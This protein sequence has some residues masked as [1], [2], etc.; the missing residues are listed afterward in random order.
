MITT[1]KIKYSCDNQSGL[2]QY[3]RQYNSC[4][5]VAVNLLLNETVVKSSSYYKKQNSII[6]QK[7]SQMNNIELMNYWM[8]LSCIDDAVALIKSR[9]ALMK[10][11]KQK[12]QSYKD[13]LKNLQNKL[14]TAKK[15]KTINNKINK[16]N[17][18]IQKLQS[19]S[20]KIIFGGRNLFE[21]RCKYNISHDEFKQLSVNPLYSIG[22]KEHTNRLFKFIS[23]T[24]VIF[25]PSKNKHFALNISDKVYRKHIQNIIYIQANKLYPITYKLDNSYIYISYDTSVIGNSIKYNH[26]V[27]NRVMSIDLNPNYTGWTVTDWKSESQFNIIKSG[28]ISIKQLNDKQFSLN[29]LSSDS[30]ERI[31]LNNKRKHEIFE[32]SKQLINICI[33]YRCQLFGYEQLK[34]YSDDKNRGRKFNS[35]CNNLWCRTALV[36]NLVKRCDIFSIQHIE[37]KPEYSSFVGN[38]LFRSLNL[39]DMCLAAFEVGR[40]S[41]EFY[42]QYII[43]T[44]EIKKNI[45]FPDLQMYNSFLTKSLEEFGLET[46]FVSLQNQYN[47]FKKS[48]TM[49]RLSIDKF[50][51]QFSRLFSLKSNVNIY[52]F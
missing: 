16:L 15:Q 43:K 6:Q 39:P 33:H 28:V 2:Q 36:N 24:E 40:R 4:L 12:L 19:K 31:K 13:D 30:P 47:L 52:Y 22:D 3:I 21:Q 32:I 44:K 45:V 20:Y 1:L 5:H 42:N 18:K 34:I 46:T 35:L 17:N 27:N 23:S 10:L 41:Y 38:F 48:K 11:D 49:Y 26:K 29:G 37:I 7:F 8:L 9:D 50:N 51:L 25:K 14:Q